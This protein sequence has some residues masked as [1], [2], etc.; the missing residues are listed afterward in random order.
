MKKL[1]LLATLLTCCA[2]L[3]A[4][5]TFR[6]EGTTTYNNP[7]TL[8]KLPNDF[9]KDLIEVPNN[10]KVKMMQEVKE[11]VGSVTPENG[12]FYF[13]GTYAQPEIYIISIPTS[14]SKS[15][16][17]YFVV[18]GSSIKVQVTENEIVISNSPLTEKLQSFTS[19]RRLLAS[20]AQPIMSEMTALGKDATE[21]QK[22]EVRKKFM[23]TQEETS[24]FIINY[25]KDNINNIVGQYA[26]AQMVDRATP[27]QLQAVVA[28][29]N[30]TTL[31]QP[32]LK[33]AAQLLNAHA[34]VNE[35]SSFTDLELVTP[36]GRKASLSDYAGR[37]KYVLI[38][39]WATWCAPCKKE[40]PL[41]VELYN[42]YKDKGFEIVGISL[43]EKKDDWVK[44]IS[45]WGMEWVHLSD[46]KG[47]RGEAATNYL[48][49]SIPYTILVDPN[50]KIIAKGLRGEGLKAKLT[51]LIK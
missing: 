11:E 30:Q 44:S 32:T 45:E 38:D 46:L 26:L 35:G 23:A 1:L 12:T 8:Y 40:I 48:V 36:E 6:I 7:I 21:E 47:F 18:D 20:K 28:E 17:T 43:D 4:Q 29:A 51:E 22:N 3:L 37:G 27:E 41:L 16:E 34:A 39:F 9:R 42:Q 25:A 13:T 2:S 31:A 24:T 15:M 14:G 19:E 49:K 33:K 10:P 5:N 50:G